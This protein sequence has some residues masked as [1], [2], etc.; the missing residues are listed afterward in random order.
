MTELITTNAHLEAAC[1]RLGKAKVL[2]VD[3]EFMREHTYWPQ[4]CIIQL[5]SAGEVVLIDALADDLSLQPFFALMADEE[6]VKVFHSARQDIEIIFHLS[7]RTV[8][9]IFDT[10]IAAM[11]CGFGES[12]GYDELAARLTGVVIDKSMRRTDWSRRPLSAHQIAYACADVTHLH[13]VYEAL[14]KQL[15]NTGRRAWI[16][17]KLA[18]LV[19]PGTYRIEP[20]HAWKR[21]KARGRSPRDL[22]ALRAAAAWREA[23]AQAANVPRG[24][25]ARDEV[26]CDL[27]RRRPA[28]LEALGE[29]RAL[30]RAL[31]R[32][33]GLAEL[34]ET[35]AAISAM[36]P[37]ELRLQEPDEAGGLSKNTSAGKAGLEM[38]R[39]LLKM[40]SEEEKVAP[41]LIAT[42]EDL[43]RIATGERDGIAA[44]EGWRHAMFGARALEVMEGRAVLRFNGTRLEFMGCPP[45]MN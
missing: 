39:I 31:R 3:T 6:I 33:E 43:A 10:Q 25:I 29:I 27:A 44:L 28:S 15:Q 41:A 34:M 13:G 38:L 16:E 4:L 42:K 24:R 5:A 32:M 26:L 17:E 19:D 7:G 37:Q 8:A 21:I 1:G 35:F 9:N 36:S 2:T 23:R 20:Y 40:V 14:W 18:A 11:V 22:A 45:H 12:A 30:P